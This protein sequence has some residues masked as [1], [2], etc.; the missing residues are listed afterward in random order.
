MNNV[1]DCHELLWLKLNYLLMFYFGIS[2]GLCAMFMTS[3]PIGKI[4][5]WNILLR[6]S[7]NK[8]FFF[9]AFDSKKIHF[10]CQKFYSKEINRPNS[11]HMLK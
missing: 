6:E 11:N 2:T 3:V 4:I 7:L 10:F 1:Y 8:C 9:I 5:S